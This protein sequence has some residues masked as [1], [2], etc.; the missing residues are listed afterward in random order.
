MTWFRHRPFLSALIVFAI[1]A[2]PSIW[3]VANIAD[4]AHDTAVRVEQLVEAEAAEDVVEERQRCELRNDAIRTAREG[5]E[6]LLDALDTILPDDPDAQQFIADLRRELP[7]DPGET[8][9]ADCDGDGD[10]DAQDYP[11]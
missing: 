10:L 5:F 8:N 2:V 6:S 7:L 4:E 3:K 1:V 11:S 9:E